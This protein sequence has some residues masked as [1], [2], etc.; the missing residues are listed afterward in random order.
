[1]FSDSIRPSF[2]YPCPVNSIWSVRLRDLFW[3]PQSSAD[4]AIELH[5]RRYWRLLW[6]FAA[7]ILA[8]TVVTPYLPMVDL[9]QHA[10]QVSM[11]R[12]FSHYATE[13]EIN[14]FTPYVLGYGISYGLS[15]VFG[16]TCAIR[17]VV[18][19]ALGAFVI[20]SAALVKEAG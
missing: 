19:L 7:L 2:C 17:V 16:V 13:Y 18:G 1:M 9:P 5:D 8:T 10:A 3:P 15:F 4:S 11:L 20:T 14:W 12:N 6:A